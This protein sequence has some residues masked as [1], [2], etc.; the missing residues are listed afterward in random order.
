MSQIGQAQVKDRRYTAVAERGPFGWECGRSVMGRLMLGVFRS[1]SIDPAVMPAALDQISNLAGGDGAL[2]IYSVHD[3]PVRAVSSADIA[4]H[5]EAYVRGDRPPDM[6]AARV[7]PRLSE[8]FR[9]D[10]DDFELSELARDPFYQEFLR[11][12]GY[13]WHACALLAKTPDGGEVHLSIKRRLDRGAYSQADVADLAAQL[14]ILRAAMTFS[15]VLPPAQMFG[16]GFDGALRRYLIGFDPRGAAFALDPAFDEQHVLTIRAGGLVC[17]DSADRHALE[18]TVA[19]ALRTGASGACELRGRDGLR[20]SLRI[21]PWHGMAG[22]HR[23][24]TCLAVLTPLNQVI[25]PTEE[26]LDTVRAI[27]GLSPAEVRIA[28]LISQ[29]M[30][31]ESVAA[32]LALSPGT[33]RNHLKS[34][35]AKTDVTRQVELSVLLSRL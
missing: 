32:Q 15:L 24:V 30:T 26:W 20:W 11:P 2:L 22:G 16:H 27:F 28:A 29:G 12:E 6:R 14:P 31:V 21:R 7:Q 33:V 18:T 35:F 23:L 17:Q 25:D 3:V 4:E 34:I 10:Q 13:G 8:G 19:R 1:A 9:F 5:T